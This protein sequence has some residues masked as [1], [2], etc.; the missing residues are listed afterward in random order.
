MIAIDQLGNAI[1]GGNPDATI[2]A[3]TGYFARVVET[4]FR[5]YWKLMEKVINFTFRPIDGSDH[6]Y[7]AYLADR[8]EKN[9]EGSDLMRGLLGIIVISTCIPLSVITRLYALV[10]PR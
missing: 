2:S 8:D 7:E 9:E 6:C 3:R 5:P 1:A 10:F 4:P